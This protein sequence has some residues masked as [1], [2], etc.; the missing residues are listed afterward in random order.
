MPSQEDQVKE[1]AEWVA[2]VLGQR[3]P[4]LELRGRILDKRVRTWTLAANGHPEAI[5][6]EIVLAA[7]RD[8]KAQHA[9][10]VAYV[11]LAFRSDPPQHADDFVN[12]LVVEMPGKGA[13]KPGDAGAIEA[14]TLAGVISQQMRQTDNLHRM[15]L[16]NLETRDAAMLRQIEILQGKLDVQEQRR[17]KEAAERM[18][19]VTLAED[20]ARDSLTREERRRR[21]AMEEKRQDWLSERLDSLIPIL[22][23]RAMGGGP[24]KGA[25]IMGQHLLMRFFSTLSSEQIDRMLDQ[26]G[27]T[28]DQ[29]SLVAELY[30]SY[31]HE[32][33]KLQSKRDH[34]TRGASAG[35]ADAPSGASNAPKDAGGA[36]S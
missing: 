8:A 2:E 25:N 36:S 16:A 18:S 11:V 34:V 5:A 21:L 35:G 23:N 24:G 1:V 4:L 6:Q 10:D 9:A 19:L 29:R 13:R 31:E 33:R 26:I 32:W 27:L 20:L 3:V 17:D 28:D 12:S 30:L 7:S 15:V 22:M 14:P